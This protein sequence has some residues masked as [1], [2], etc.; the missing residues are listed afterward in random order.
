[1]NILTP[2]GCNSK[3][4]P[5]VVSWSRPVGPT[6]PQSCPFL[7]TLCYAERI[8]PE[9]QAKWEANAPRTDWG[10]WSRQLQIELSE[11]GRR[12]HQVRIHVGG[13]FLLPSGELDRDYI[14]AVLRAYV[15]AKPRPASWCYTHVWREMDWFRGMFVALG[16]EM[17]ASVHTPEEA[18]EARALGWRLAID[19]GDRPD[20]YPAWRAKGELNCPEQRLGHE[21][22]TCSTCRYCFRAGAG[23]VVFYLHGPGT[24]NYRPGGKH[25]E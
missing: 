23:D 2:P 8:A 9:V 21:R 6:C 11:A 1:M 4:G 24:K 19:G 12:G 13:D 5:T 7:H 25:T 22:I 15:Y 14:I 10:P 3:L 18:S 20:S 16:I 17:F